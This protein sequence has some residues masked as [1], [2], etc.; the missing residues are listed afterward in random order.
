[1]DLSFHTSYGAD[2]FTSGKFFLLRLIYLCSLF[3]Y[4]PVFCLLIFTVPISL[5]RPIYYY[6]FNF[7]GIL[8]VIAPPP[9]IAIRIL[10]IYSVDVKG[11]FILLP[12]IRIHVCRVLIG[13]VYFQMDYD[14]G[15][16]I[17]H[18]EEEVVARVDLGHDLGVRAGHPYNLA[19]Q[20]DTTVAAALLADPALASAASRCL[21]GAKA[22]GTVR[23]YTRAL[24]RFQ[25]WFT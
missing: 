1:V 15:L 19:L 16:A 14:P 4:T 11:I 18:H 25:V 9:S 22:T 10:F 23:S 7:I 5:L 2:F 21:L 6:W 12:H 13:S 3:I 17:I 8:S 24:Q 20:E